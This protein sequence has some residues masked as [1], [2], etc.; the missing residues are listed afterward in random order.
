MQNYILLLIAVVGWS[1]CSL[2]VWLLL[3]QVRVLSL[4]VYEDRGNR[5]MGVAMIAL[6]PITVIAGYLSVFWLWCRD[7]LTDAGL[8]ASKYQHPNRERP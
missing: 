4:E 5:A 2:F 6:G 3:R 1:G 7:S 8:D